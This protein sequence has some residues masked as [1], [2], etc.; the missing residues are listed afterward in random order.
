MKQSVNYSASIPFVE[1][2][3]NFF[4]SMNANASDICNNYSTLSWDLILRI[5]FSFLLHGGCG[6]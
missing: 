2:F 6:L 3:V 1:A 5:I 4:L